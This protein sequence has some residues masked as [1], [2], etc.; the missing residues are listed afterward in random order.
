MSWYE[1][2]T[3]IKSLGSQAER[4]GSLGNLHKVRKKTLSQF[5]TTNDIQ[6]LC[7][8]IIESS[9]GYA[10]RSKISLMDNSCAVGSLFWLA[11]PQKHHLFGC[12]IHGESVDAL[13]DAL[14]AADFDYDIINSG[15]ENISFSKDRFDFS[16]INPPFSLSLESPHLKN[17]GCNHYGEYGPNSSAL[18]HEYALAQAKS[19]SNIVIAVLPTNFA[20]KLELTDKN[21]RA[22]YD[23]PVNAFSEQGALVKTSVCVFNRFTDGMIREKVN[24]DFKV[25]N[26]PVLKLSEYMGSCS[27]SKRGLSFSKPIITMPVTGDKSVRVAHNG[28]KIILGFK[29]GLMQAKVLNAVYVKS[30]KSCDDKMKLA[31]HVKYVGQGRLDCE[32]HLMQTDPVMSI[33]QNLVN[34]I[35]STG[36]VVT[37]DDGLINYI[38]KRARKMARI[39]EPMRHIVYVDENTISESKYRAK[40]DVLIEE[41]SFISPVINKGE[42]IDVVERQ[43]IFYCSCEGAEYKLSEKYIYDNFEMVQK[44]EGGKWIAKYEGKSA[45][46]PEL[47]HEINARAKKLLLQK[48][49][50]KFQLDDICELTLSPVGSILG[51]QMG[52][53]K[54][55]QILASILLA[56]VKH[57]LIVVMSKLVF[58][59]IRQIKE[60]LSDYIDIND[61]NVI[62]SLETVNNLK[63]INIVSYSRLSCLPDRTKPNKTYANH[64]RRRCGLV[65]ADEAHLLSN[66]STLQSRAVRQ[67]SAK[68]LILMTG[69]PIPNQARNI[70]PLLI[71]C[72]GDGCSHMPWG[73]H[74]HLMPHHVNNMNDSFSSNKEFMDMFVTMKWVT[75]MFSDTMDEGAK[76]EIPQIRNVGEY[77]Q[78]LAP[79]MKRRVTSEP[80]CVKHVD[81]PKPEVINTYLSW[82]DEHLEHYLKV[83]TEFKHVWME[84]MKKVKDGEVT[85]MHSIL[86]RIN[87][88]LAAC[89]KPFVLNKDSGVIGIHTEP[90][91]KDRYCVDSLIKRVGDGEKCILFADSP[92]TINRLHDMLALRGFKSL[93]YTGAITAPKRA[94]LLNDEYKNGNIDILLATKKCLAEGENVE[95]ASYACF[96]GRD[97]L[98]KNEAQ[99]YS[100]LLRP[101]QLK[102]VTIEYVMLEGSI[103]IYQ[104]Q[105][106]AFKREV[107]NEGLDFGDPLLSDTE[108]LH[109]DTIIYQF[110]RDLEDMNQFVSN[111]NKAA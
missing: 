106:V 83:C 10:Q 37:V 22:I 73:L 56:N 35:S 80:D 2:L 90:T 54:T 4:P 67:L 16:L 87:A 79:F 52:L 12:D 39:V 42:F 25:S 40:V 101:G 5:F 20:N 96:Y 91:S 23:L 89:N 95:V 74:G 98:N 21:L 14:S 1:N 63:K 27:I 46:F 85:S 9:E 34:I 28:R 82:D 18:S 107:A 8:D 41:D 50:W 75:N 92:D 53:G 30:A 47:H 77:R 62:D 93:V 49:L 72:A 33:Y 84:R 15:M 55:R 59:F 66:T 26:Y 32:L 48:W 88:V 24:A 68:K 61:V 70:L 51:A 43:G 102:K 31:K 99:C 111:K 86:P 110:V 13:C 17:L 108:F 94:Q 58:E 3:N 29:C 45:A 64:L 19:V 105:M 69:T 71:A 6:R 7:W 78:L 38:K 97:W 65:L 44:G 81:L 103:D 100:R 76:R 109:M 104:E 60:D 11:D 36:A 57:G